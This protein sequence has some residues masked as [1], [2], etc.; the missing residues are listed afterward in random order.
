MN[1]IIFNI[2][3]FIISYNIDQSIVNWFDIVPWSQNYIFYTIV[4]NLPISFLI[5]VIIIKKIKQLLQL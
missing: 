5:T 3:L 2:I 4:F 1:Y